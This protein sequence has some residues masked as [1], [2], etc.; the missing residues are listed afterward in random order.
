MSHCDV[1][2]SGLNWNDYYLSTKIFSRHKKLQNIF[3]QFFSH[4]KSDFYRFLFE[5]NFN[6]PIPDQEYTYVKT[7]IPEAVGGIELLRRF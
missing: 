3:F 4:S 6:A 5:K 7:L 2:I 1:I